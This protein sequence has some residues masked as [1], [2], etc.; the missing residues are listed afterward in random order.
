[1]R[2]DNIKV[3]HPLKSFLGRYGTKKVYLNNNYRRQLEHARSPIWNN[4][5]AVVSHHGNK[6]LVV[7]SSILNN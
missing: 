2:D 1:M 5:R 7:D 3:A 6:L 4:L